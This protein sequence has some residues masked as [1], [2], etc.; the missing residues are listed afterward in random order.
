MTSTED[1]SKI[2]DIILEMFQKFSTRKEAIE[3]LKKK[4]LLP[5]NFNEKEKQKI[6]NKGTGAGG[7]RT[8]ETGLKFE[9]EANINEHYEQ[10]TKQEI[11]E[12]IKFKQGDIP[13]LRLRKHDLGKW[14]KML[15][16]DEYNDIP[17]SA[18]TILPDDCYVDTINKNMIILEKKSQQGSGSVIEKL[19]SPKDKIRN[20]S[21]RYIGYHVH[22]I[23]WLSDWYDSHA[24]AE[25]MYFRRD[26][27]PYVIGFSPSEK[28]EVAN[29]IINCK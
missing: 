19:Q 9:E 5:K 1:I 28:L 12:T 29:I 8:N 20:L 11:G 4:G 2:I 10:R 6:I 15:P 26:K 13:F 18:G 24:E 3:A 27:I 16:K 25:L 7:S 17:K 22:Y 21:E 14:T 23:Y